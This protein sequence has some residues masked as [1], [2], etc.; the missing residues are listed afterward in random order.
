M[1]D[2]MVFYESFYK[3][4]K[5][6]PKYKR[7]A[8]IDEVLEY[9]F[10]DKVPEGENPLFISAKPQIDACNERWKKAKENGKKGGRPKT[11]RL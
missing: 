7:L 6:F 1:K 2:S 4:S 3:L 11:L 5:T 9:A 8:Q 10:Y